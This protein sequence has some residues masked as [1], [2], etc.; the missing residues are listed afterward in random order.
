MSGYWFGYQP[1]EQAVAAWGCRAIFHNSDRSLEFLW[2]RQ[3]GLEGQTEKQNDLLGKFINQKVQPQIRKLAAYMDVSSGDVITEHFE[4]PH[5]PN[6]LIVVQGSPQRSYGYFYL[7]V[8]LVPHESA[9]PVQR[10]VGYKT[11][12]ERKEIAKRLNQRIKELS[13]ER[14]RN[15]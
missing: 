15:Y 11:P 7:A 12:A 14:K 6:L 4:W 5:D 10:P 8:N 2:D 13:A 9:P 3:Q 1:L